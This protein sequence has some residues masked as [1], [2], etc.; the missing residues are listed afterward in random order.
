MSNQSK[1]QLLWQKARGINKIFL[2]TVAL[3]TLTAIIYFGLIASDVFISESRFVVRSPQR[4][5]VAGLG[6][7]LQG[8][9]FSRAQD[10]TFTVHDYILSRDALGLLEKEIRVSA[11]FKR[12]EIDLLSRFAPLG[13]DESFEEF[14]LYYSKRVS[15]SANSQSAISTLKVR[16]YSAE[17]AQLINEKLLQISEQLINSLNERGRQ[18]MVRFA[19]REVEQAENKAKAAALALSG[20]RNQKGVIDPER[21]SSLQLQQIAKMYDE[22]L[23]AKAQL[24]QLRSLAKDN[25]QIPTLQKRVDMLQTA[26][27]SENARIAG[28]E[29][30]LANKAAEFQRLAL[31]REFADRQLAVALASLEQA[32][33]EAVRKQL[34][35]ERVAQPGLPDKAM[36]PRR[37]HGVLATLAVGLLAWGVLT[38]LIAAVREHRD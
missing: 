20:Y 26:I 9:G 10:D 14:F 5:S 13:L 33:N 16:A 31:E 27:D 3:P 1:L 36:E 25:P 21:Q 7:L 12:E 6:A 4:Q 29:K 17:D 8:A 28:G 15:I 19:A 34:Y 35:L 30:S 37:L 24:A 38:L 2:F 32:R 11:L 23:T 22:L 18:D